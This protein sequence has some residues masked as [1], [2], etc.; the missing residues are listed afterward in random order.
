MKKLGTVLLF[1][2]LSVNAVA[3]KID[4]DE[5]SR[6]LIGT[7]NYCATFNSQW[8]MIDDSDS[9]AHDNFLFK[10]CYYLTISEMNSKNFKY[11]SEYQDS[12]L[13]P[14]NHFRGL[15]MFIGCKGSNQ[16]LYSIKSDELMIG[17]N[18]V[19]FKNENLGATGHFIYFGLIIDS[20]Q[21]WYKFI[22]E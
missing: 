11:I 14:N 3:Q 1:S 21:Y 12:L 2:L 4:V 7:Y 5:Q 16:Y 10:T 22:K 19:S 13:S 15:K 9:L 18:L 17:D 8:K 6:E 20:R